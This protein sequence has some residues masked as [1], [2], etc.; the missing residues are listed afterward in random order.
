M[1]ACD[2]YWELSILT[3]TYSSAGLAVAVKVG[4]DCDERS[5]LS[6]KGRCL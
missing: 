6:L 5:E 3:L 1:G 4:V 2:E